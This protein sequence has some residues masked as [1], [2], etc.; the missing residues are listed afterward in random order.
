MRFAARLEELGAET[1]FAVSPA[2][3]PTYRPAAPAPPPKATSQPAAKAEAPPS[4]EATLSSGETP[5]TAPIPGTIIRYTVNEGDAVKIGD[6]VVVLEA[7]KMENEI[8][9]PVDGKVKAIRFKA[10]DKV[11]GGDILAVIG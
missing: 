10:G 8:V 11:A 1:A 9:S 4:K 3:A 7:M 6:G 2:N 5:V